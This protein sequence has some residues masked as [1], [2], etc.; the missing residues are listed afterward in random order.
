MPEVVY[1]QNGEDGKPR[2]WDVA[3][4]IWQNDDENTEWQI[5]NQILESIA[6]NNRFGKET[7]DELQARLKKDQ[8]EWFVSRLKQFEGEKHDH[9][10]EFTSH[11]QFGCGEDCV[12]PEDRQKLME[13][14]R[15]VF[16]SYGKWLFYLE[17]VFA[18]LG[19]AYREFKNRAPATVQP[20]MEN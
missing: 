15:H 20:T 14:R 5:I 17:E 13:Q 18:Q 4:P 6:M 2:T 16:Q 19:G 9:H 1:P 10:E 11:T 12:I 8:H 3:F 7:V